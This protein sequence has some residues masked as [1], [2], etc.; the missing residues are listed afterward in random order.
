MYPKTLI[1]GM[2]F[3]EI[4]IMIGLVAVLFLADKM[5]V[6]RKF[7]IKL[8]RLLILS[9]AGGIGIGFFGAI[10]FQSVYNYIATGEFSLKSGMTFY[11]GLIFGAGLFLIAW[12]FG[13]K[14]YKA[15]DEAKAR[16][17]DVADMAACLIPLAHGFG[18]MGCLFAGC[19]HGKA[20]DA[21]YGIAHYNMDMNYKG[22]Y[23]P[24]Q[25]F[26]AL[27]L[28]AL[29]G[30]MMWL[31]FSATKKGEK[32]FPLF[33]V[34]LIIYGI[35]RFFIEY[36]RGDERGQTIVS[37]L[38][39]SQLVAVVLFAVGVGYVLVWWFVFRK[40]KAA[41]RATPAETAEGKEEKEE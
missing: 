27:F 32:K 14:L 3:Y 30:L 9:A 22:T 21:W 18:R 1:A 26:E 4:F 33:P 41:E 5:S 10:L 38:S 11:G 34:Y 15:Q 24:V 17:G 28:F 36:A 2:G 19:C 37:F 29:S 25:L 12:F 40:K 8:Q 23:V 35:W 7:S 13:S 20:T 31:F 39:P 6:K 16:F